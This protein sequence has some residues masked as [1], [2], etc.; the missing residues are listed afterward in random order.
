MTH[1]PGGPVTCDDSDFLGPDHV[2]FGTDASFSTNDGKD[3]ILN[4]RYSVEAMN[5]SNKEIQNIFSNACCL[6][7][8]I[9]PRSN[10]NWLHF[11]LTYR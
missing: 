5:L 10:R 1:S 2:L 7:P 9:R 3:G 11:L 4:A 8:H 6:P